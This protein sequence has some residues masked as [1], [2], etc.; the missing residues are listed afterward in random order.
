LNLAEGGTTNVHK[1]RSDG[2]NPPR[3]PLSGALNGKTPQ[4]AGFCFLRANAEPSLEAEFK[5]NWPHWVVGQDRMAF[6]SAPRLSRD[7]RK[8]QRRRCA[9]IG[10]VLID[11]AADLAGQRRDQ[12][13]TRTGGV[14]LFDSSTVIGHTQATLAVAD[15]RD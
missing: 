14:V 2:F 4:S 10:T 15:T 13:Q 7:H 3:S 1:A 6:H 5:R 8:G 9:L 12:F 11:R